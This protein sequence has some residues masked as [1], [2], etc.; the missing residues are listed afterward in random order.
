MITLHKTVQFL[1]LKFTQEQLSKL[2]HQIV[3]FAKEKDIRYQKVDETQ[4][5]RTYKVNAYPQFMRDDIQRIV[6]HF[7]EENGIR[8]KRKR[9]RIKRIEKV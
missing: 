7:A 1:G 8:V 2:G 5:G 4:G 3:A 9:A 6:K